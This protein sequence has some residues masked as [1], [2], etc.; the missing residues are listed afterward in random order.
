MTCQ[1]ELA[2]HV[3][4]Y[5]AIREA[6]GLTNTRHERGLRDFIAYARNVGAVDGSPI[7]AATAVAW[8]WD[9]APATCGIRGRGDRLIVVRGFLNYLAAIIPGT[10]VPGSRVIA[11][12]RR[13]RPYV[14]SDEEMTTLI[15]AARRPNPRV[16]FRPIVLS[17]LL[18]L[19]A[20]TG[21][22]VAE[23]CRLSLDDIRLGDAHPHLQILQTKFHKSRIVPIHPT[24]VAA[25]SG[26]LEERHAHKHD[27]WGDRLFVNRDG[28]PLDVHDLGHWFASLCQSLGI[29]PANTHDRRPCLTSFRHTFAVRRLR[30]W[31]SAGLDVQSLLPTLAVYL[32]HVG[33]ESS[34]WYLS[35]TPNLLRAAGARFTLDRS[36]GGEG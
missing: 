21:L 18:G 1:L 14:F 9:Q 6:V 2:Q 19:L 26:Y 11:A 22:R 12:G 20:S 34:Y 3:D 7:R 13:R 24:V 23:A 16:P 15:G 36:A 32:G 17:T 33:P 31:H 25:L 10:E 4:A 28:R 8:A 5:L 27:I 30:E 29:E 35:A